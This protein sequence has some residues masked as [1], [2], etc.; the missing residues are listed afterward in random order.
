[1]LTAARA[2]SRASIPFFGPGAAVMQRCYDKLEA[3]RI[4]AGNG[5][6]CP[7]TTTADAAGALAFP[8][9]LNPRRGSDSIGVRLLRA[10]PIPARKRTID[11]VAQE[12]VRGAELTV[13]VIGNRVG[14]PLRIFLPEGVPYS[15]LRKYLFRPRHAPV[16]DPELAERVRAMALKIASV[17]GVNWAARIDLIHETATDRLRFLECDVAPLV[18][19]RSAFAVSLGAAGV[20]RP[21]Q[22]RLLLDGA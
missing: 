12:H 6:D 17:F 19:A 9:I 3:H 8:L 22:L 16:A 15:F 21:E 20:T 4:A 14:I 13:G 2:L 10:G 1:M 7:A 18:V 5:V 11:Y